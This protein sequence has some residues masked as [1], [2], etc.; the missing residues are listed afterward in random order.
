MKKTIAL[1][2]SLV[3]LFCAVS[4]F[5][6]SAKKSEYKL[7]SYKD[8]E[9]FYRGDGV[10][11]FDYYGT[12][13]KLKIPS[14]IN[15]HKVVKIGYDGSE[16]EKQYFF[17][18]PA[19]SWWYYGFWHNEYIE[20]VTI[21]D[22]V[23]ALSGECF[24]CCPRLKKVNLGK[25]L[26]SLDNCEFSGC[27]KLRSLKLPESLESFATDSIENTNITKLS[28][29][30][31]LRKFDGEFGGA[32]L[33][34]VSVSRDNKNFAS[35]KGA[36][37]DKAKTKLV[38]YPCENKNKALKLP[39]GI[40]K[41]DSTTLSYT[42]LKSITLPKKLSR[43][44]NSAIYCNE[45]LTQLKFSGKNKIRVD[46]YAVFNCKR[47]TSVKI[48]KNVVKIGKK[49]FGF[50]EYEYKKNGKEKWVDK[51]VKGFTIRG[52]KN[53][54]AYKYARKYGFKFIEI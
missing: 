14:K 18:L 27:E 2:L 25:G 21:P 1:I 12:Q 30:K 9:Y 19:E 47:L 20:E 13:S 26:K 36:L 17:Y 5:S 40:T 42:N 11:I 28:F 22:T 51:K 45:K 35:E 53:S 29:G 32:Q 38:Y 44:C 31:N 34:F 3:T 49:A 15:G 37:Y 8:Y 48:P 50:W 41:L 52:K 4:V 16:D 54:A 39:D 7:Y 6:A 33:A 46:S 24:K 43:I 23:T 10:Q